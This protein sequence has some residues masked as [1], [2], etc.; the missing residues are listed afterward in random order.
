MSDNINFEKAMSELESI[1][2]LLEKGDL[3]LEESLKQFEQGILLA[4]HCQN[5][6]SKAEQKIETLINTDTVNTTNE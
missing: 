4:R 5:T 3:P 2:T 6:L 1:V